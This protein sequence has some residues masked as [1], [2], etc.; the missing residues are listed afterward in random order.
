MVIRSENRPI[1]LILGGS[2]GLGAATAKKM[3]K[4]GY[5]LVIVHRDRKSEMAKVTELFD[6]IGALGARC[7][8]FNADA[9]HAAKQ[10]D[11]W[12]DIK[13]EL[14]E[15]RIK[16]VVHSIAK[17]NLKPMTGSKDDLTNQDFQ[18]TLQAMA[19]S[20]FDWVKRIA[21]DGYFETDARVIAFTSE[22]SFKPLA[23]YAA[24]SAAKS[25]LETIVR[26]IALEFAPKGIKANCIQAGVTNTKSFRM[27]PNHEALLEHAQRRNPNKRLT[28]PNDVA[29]AVYL[30]TL[31]EASWITGTVIKVDGGENLQ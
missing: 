16:I 30:L 15:K 7:H 1:A 13:S 14:D 25:A 27:I 28:T 20:L 21:D 3:A 24:V 2:S 4:E 26:S 17:G 19:I 8:T 12:S 10:Q 9:V 31:P 23:N 6:E 5:D 18:L 22:G 11:L 29:N